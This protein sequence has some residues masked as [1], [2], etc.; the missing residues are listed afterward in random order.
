MVGCHGEIQVLY[1]VFVGSGRYSVYST[2]MRM[3]RFFTV[4]HHVVLNGC[5]QRLLPLSVSEQLAETLSS[6]PSVTRNRTSCGVLPDAPVPG[7]GMMP[8]MLD[9]A[10]LK[11]VSV[12]LFRTSSARA[13]QAIVVVDLQHIDVSGGIRCVG[14]IGR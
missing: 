2:A 4:V 5:W 13:G 9:I 12:S 11:S 7:V 8:L 6:T 3:P 10:E 1:Q 14:Q